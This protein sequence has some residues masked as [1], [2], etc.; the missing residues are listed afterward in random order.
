MIYKK[1]S[2]DFESVLKRF[3]EVSKISAQKNSE[4]VKRAK[5][6]QSL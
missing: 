1:L 2:K 6:Q 3:Q 5:Q 4:I